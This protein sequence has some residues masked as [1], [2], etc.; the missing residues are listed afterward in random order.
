M[1]FSRHARKNMRL[2]KIEE[3]DILKVLEEP[4]STSREGGRLT[5]FKQ[6]SKKFSGYTLKVVYERSKKDTTI[7]TAYPLKKKHW[8]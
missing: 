2:Y 5:A 7:I 3:Q 1:R 6:F 4:D 8:R